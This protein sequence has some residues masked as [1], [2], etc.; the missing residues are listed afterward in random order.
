MGEEKKSFWKCTVCGWIFE[1]ILPPDIC[2]VCKAGREAFMPAVPEN[3]TCRND[4][5]MKAVIIGSG[6][7][8]VSAAEALQKRNN[9]A[10][11][12]IYTREDSFPYYRPILIRAMRE[13][14]KP[15][16]YFIHP[17]PFYKNRKI[18]VHTKRTAL[19]LDTAGRTVEL[20]GGEKV[21]YDSL[22][23]ATGASCWTPKMPGIHLP[24]VVTLR[25]KADF[26]GL[27]SILDARKKIVVMGGGLL[28]LETASCL[29]GM[30]HSILIV[31]A[32]PAILPTHSDA[33]SSRMLGELIVRAGAE[34]RLGSRICSIDG[35]DRV[36]GITLMDGHEIPC[37]IVIISAGIVSNSAIAKSAGIGTNRGILVDAQ[38][39]SSAPDV[40]AAGDCSEF[41]SK[42]NGVWE[43]AQEQGRIAGANIAGDL[44]EYQPRTSG[45]VLNAFGTK[46]FSIGEIGCKEGL[47]KVGTDDR[48]NNVYKAVMFKD[49]KAAG[50][51][52]L[53][54]TS[55]TCTLIA[56]V[57]NGWDSAGC[58][59]NG[60]IQ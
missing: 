38:M 32:C 7:A 5:P 56:A 20:D 9:L 50:G 53:G 54:D 40:F 25:E 13:Q 6:A 41:N 46:L 22:V 24:G 33:E 45:V 48:R 2:P 4:R 18:S 10:Q 26:D 47:E 14:I 36:R 17:D 28:G 58:A 12:D 55:L 21:A 51:I 43:T 19:A 31:E 37:D 44:A 30:G 11:I 52:L 8:A 16:E 35:G 27:K 42:I 23:L 1:G 3:V 57:H 49:G 15:R 29:A 59:R 39:R 60:L 34:I